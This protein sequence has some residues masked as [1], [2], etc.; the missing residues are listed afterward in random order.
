MDNGFPVTVGFLGAMG[1]YGWLP[2]LECYHGILSMNFEVNGWVQYGTKTQLPIKAYNGYLE[3][4]WGTNFPQTWIWL[5]ANSFTDSPGTS[6]TLALARLPIIGDSVLSKFGFLGGFYHKGELHQFGTYTWAS[7]SNVEIE[8]DYSLG[9]RHIFVSV[10]NFL[11]NKSLKVS[12]SIPLDGYSDEENSKYPKLMVP[13][14]SGRM[15]PQLLE[16]VDASLSVA[17]YDGVEQ[18]IFTSR[19]ATVECHSPDNKMIYM[20]T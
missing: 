11:R 6:L 7:V 1:Y 17:F 16:W 5:Q 14:Q 15:L 13:S 9:R 19:P 18:H 3:K 20:T 8:D 12:A 2:F 10:T 4:D